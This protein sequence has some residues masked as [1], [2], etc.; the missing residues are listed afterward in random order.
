MDK[1]HEID[2]QI[3]ILHFTLQGR[4]PPRQVLIEE[5]N[6]DLRSLMGIVPQLMCLNQNC[7]KNFALLRTSIERPFLISP[8]GI[9]F[10][11]DRLSKFNV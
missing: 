7:T 10:K 9:M 3:C 2:P 8:S 6:E 5:R 4:R 11:F 1:L